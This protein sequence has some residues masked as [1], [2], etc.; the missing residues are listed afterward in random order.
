M[1]LSPQERRR[2]WSTFKAMSWPR[3]IDYVFTYFKLPLALVTVALVAIGSVVHWQLTHKEVVLYTAY[4]NVSIEEGMDGSLTE[5]FVRSLG[6]DTRTHEVRCYRALYL[7]DEASPSNHEYA[8]ASRLKVL[9]SID[10]RELDVVLM[11]Q[12]AYDVFSHNGYLLDLANAWPGAEGT[13]PEGVAGHLAT[14]TVIL[15]DN[16]L[17]VTLSEEDEYQALTEEVANALEVTDL[18][19]FQAVD[20]SGKVYLG[21]IANSPRT[22]AAVRFI[23]YLLTAHA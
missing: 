22:K 9:A 1:R 21:I 13:A 23:G 18:P 3:R 2:L 6:E 10:A 7:S 5:G 16:A 12:E 19:P 8:Y 11:N 15:G 20:F 17:E 4:A 14:N